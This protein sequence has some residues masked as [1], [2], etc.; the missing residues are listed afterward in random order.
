M[1]EFA[2]I[3]Q[4]TTILKQTVFARFKQASVEYLWIMTGAI[5]RLINEPNAYSFSL[6]ADQL[7]LAAMQESFRHHY[8]GCEPYKKLCNKE[9]FL[10]ENLIS[11][12]QIPQ[13]PY[14]FVNVF[15]EWKLTSVP[16]SQISVTLSSSGTGGKKSAI[17]LDN[18]SLDRVTRMATHIY[19]AYGIVN[20]EQ[21]ANYLCFTYDPKIAGDVGTTFTDELMRGFTKTA[22][23]FYALQWDL[24]T[25]QFFFD[26]E[27]CL[28][29]LER[30]ASEDIP[31]RILGFPAYTYTVVQE[32][33]VRRKTGLQFRQD[34][35]VLIGGGWKTLADK[36]IPKFRF[37][38]E[39]SE[40]LR[41]P[42]KNIRDLFGMVEHGVPYVDCEYGELHI[43]IYSRVYVREPRTMKILPPGNIGLFQF[44]TPYI[45]SFPSI[46][47]LGSDLGYVRTDCKCG[48]NAPYIVILGRGGIKKH[49]GCAITA[50]EFL[51]KSKSIKQSSNIEEMNK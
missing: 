50:L 37:R 42:E 15:K 48:R 2:Y 3:N 12:E 1:E 28:A 47:L 22:K 24:N 38:H 4:P 25:K 43:P 40:A 41:I 49:Q 5:E 39:I 6:E 46:S 31:L 26:L 8:D 33:L 36:E 14:I 9:K 18:I 13:I 45:N 21:S 23:V 51:K 16:D 44:I 29:T 17:H 30:F 27:E 35:Y 34:S 32:L 10:P 11:Y 20:T 19:D 7:F